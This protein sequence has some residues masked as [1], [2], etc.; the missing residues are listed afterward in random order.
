MTTF[1]VITR[2]N[3][4][5]SFDFDQGNISVGRSPENDITV[6]DVSVSRK[7]L[8]ILISEG[9]YYIRDLK[10]TNGT[11]LNKRAIDAGDEYEVEEGAPITL[12]RTIISIGKAFEGDPSE[13]FDE[14]D[15]LKEAGGTARIQEEGRSM[16]LKNNMGFIYRLSRMLAEP[17]EIKR[18][19][20]MSLDLIFDLLKRIDRGQIFLMDFETGAIKDIITRFR[21]ETDD[22]TVMFSQNVMDRVLEKG[23]AVMITDSSVS[24]EV[25][26]SQDLRS[27]GI[28]STLCV[29]LISRSRTW[30]LI[31]LDSVR[32]PHGFRDEDLELI[33]AVSV[34]ISLALE[35]A[36]LHSRLDTNARG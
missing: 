27:L 30:G 16:T 34:P 28:D 10:S 8:I 14:N 32:G 20:E 25:G 13:F 33:T 12:G 22:A 21:K 36:W 35:N 29:P 31:Y 24:G 5:E 3:E 4:R 6:E 11:F 19:L 26:L 1:H 9:K 2:S 17:S 18:I 7:H 23:K 15:F